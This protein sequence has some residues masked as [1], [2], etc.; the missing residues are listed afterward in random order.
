MP[1]GRSLIAFLA[2]VGPLAA[3]ELS[4]L[5]GKKVNGTLGSINDATVSM[6]TD[7][8]PIEAPLAKVLALTIRDP[9][10]ADPE[11]KFTRV[12]LLDE[13]VLLCKSLKFEGAKKVQL[14]LQ[15]GAALEVPTT[16]VVAYLRDA[17]N[18]AL[19]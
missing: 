2:L 4:L 13:S 11:T 3:D 5:D 14:T 10:S 19:A 1:F 7:A 6:K 18:P 17:Q 15:S 16:F 9:K 12:H 8:G